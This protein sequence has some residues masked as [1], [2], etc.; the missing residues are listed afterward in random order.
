VQVQLY[1]RSRDVLNIVLRRYRDLG[2]EHTDAHETR[3]GNVHPP[4]TKGDPSGAV[5][6]VIV[7]YD[8]YDDCAKRLYAIVSAC[9]LARSS[10]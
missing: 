2:E 5:A 8:A 7:G 3:Q 10:H 4:E 9:A 1:I 6:V